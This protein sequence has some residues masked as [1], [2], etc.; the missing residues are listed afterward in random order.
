MIYENVLSDCQVVEIGN[1]MKVARENF[2]RGYEDG[3][4]EFSGKYGLFGGAVTLSV[5]LWDSCQD[6]VY[7]AYQ[8]YWFDRWGEGVEVFGYDED[9][10]NRL[11]GDGADDAIEAI[12]ELVRCA[13]KK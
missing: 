10:V 11:W 7:S 13:H 1:V 2:E 9:G 6:G 5:C 3:C 8:A 4:R 12:G